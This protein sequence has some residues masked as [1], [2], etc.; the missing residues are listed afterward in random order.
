MKKLVFILIIALSYVK[1]SAQSTDQKI[2]EVYAGKTQEFMEQTPDWYPSLKDVV[3]KRVTI[4]SLPREPQEKFLKLSQ[5]GL[6]N[7]YNANLQRDVTFDPVTFNPLKYDFVFSSK[8]VMVYRVDNSDYIIV[9][10]PQQS[11]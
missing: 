8:A 9:I 4:K 6:L 10:E 11:K 3:E 7:K 1:L 2:R 5:I